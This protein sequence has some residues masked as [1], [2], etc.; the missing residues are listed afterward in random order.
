VVGIYACNI[1]D[2]MQWDKRNRKENDAW[3]ENYC[4]NVSSQ[5]I[6]CVVAA[7]EMSFNYTAL[8]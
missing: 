6:S 8:L 5:A 4:I 2:K 7:G 3:F 1:L